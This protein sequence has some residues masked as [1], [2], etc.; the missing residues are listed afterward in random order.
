MWPSPKLN[1]GTR[2]PTNNRSLAVL[3]TVLLVDWF[4]RRGG[5][6][7]LVVQRSEWEPDA[8]ALV[9]IDDEFM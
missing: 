3:S 9:G 1:D 5:S 8:T 2:Q 6:V 4:I 7:F